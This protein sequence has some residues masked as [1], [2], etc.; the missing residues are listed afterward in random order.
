MAICDD[1]EGSPSRLLALPPELRESILALVVI[2]EAI[3]KPKIIIPRES[4]VLRLPPI[5]KVNRQLRIESLPLY[6]EEN[7]FFFEADDLCRPECP[8]DIRSNRRLQTFTSW[9]EAA[10]RENVQRIR[11]FI[12]ADHGVRCYSLQLSRRG[13]CDFRGHKNITSALPYA[14]SSPRDRD[15]RQNF[16]EVEVRDSLRKAVIAI[17]QK[18]LSPER[19]RRICRCISDS[20]DTS[21]SDMDRGY[22]KFV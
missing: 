7:V 14:G 8:R 21:R 2:D 4:F 12:F 6:Y 11:S 18:G 19:I 22:G 15:W 1:S 5:T 3:I 20:V 10:G 16:C 9:C 17:A 13:E